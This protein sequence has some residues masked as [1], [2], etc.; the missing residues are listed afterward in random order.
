MFLLINS[1][2][3]QGKNFVSFVSSPTQQKLARNFRAKA[4]FIILRTYRF[5]KGC[6]E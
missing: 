1:D 5:Q 2:S 3:S 6:D 4:L